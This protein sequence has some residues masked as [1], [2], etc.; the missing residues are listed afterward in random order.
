MSGDRC[1][2]LVDVAVHLPETGM[3]TESVEDRI[4]ALNPELEVP[5]GLLG[6]FTG[7][8]Y[9]H[10]QPAGSWGIDLGVRAAQTLLARNEIRAEDLDLV[11]F[12]AASTDVLEPAA[13]HVVAAELG[14]SC[15]VF[16]VHNACNSLLNAIEVADAL[17]RAGAYRTVLVV[18]GETLSRAARWR[19]D[20]VDE[21]IASG[22]SHSLSDGGA[23]L[24][25][26]GADEPGILA[27]RACANSDAWRSVLLPLNWTESAEPTAGALQVRTVDLY[28]AVATLDHDLPAKVLAELG[29]TVDDVAVFCVHQPADA[30]LKDFCERSGIPLERTINTIRDHGNL[31]AATLPL[32]L[33]LAADSGRLRR[34]DI[35]VLIGLASGVSLGILVLRW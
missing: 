24:L 7:V 4:A 31:S 30:Y 14:A 29:L 18:C 2:R 9:R 34:G 19:F 8:R 5:R 21:Y 28:R 12:A 3:D 17:I 26:E 32:Q 15:P 6:R 25:L 27:H 1:P 13:A 23:A 20:T 16:D 35:A 33:T 10:V 11:I 22:A